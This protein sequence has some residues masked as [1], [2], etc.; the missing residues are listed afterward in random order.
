[1]LHVVNQTRRHLNYEFSEFSHLLLVLA[2][3]EENRLNSILNLGFAF[4]SF[5]EN[6]ISRSLHAVF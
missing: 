5:L 4:A 2:M 3:Y 1:M 6:A